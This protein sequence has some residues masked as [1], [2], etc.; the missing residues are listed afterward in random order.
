MDRVLVETDAP[1]LSPEPMRGRRNEPAN[2]VH[3]AAKLAE[4]K[5]VSNAEIARVTTDNFYVLFSK[6]P[7]PEGDVAA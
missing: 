7:R 1:Y 6:V 4:V 2:V 3:T 5:G